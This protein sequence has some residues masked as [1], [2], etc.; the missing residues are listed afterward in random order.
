MFHGSVA[1]SPLGSIQ[2]PPSLP[3]SL[4]LS[5][6]V[7]VVGLPQLTSRW[8]SGSWSCFARWKIFNLLQKLMDDKIFTFSGHRAFKIKRVGFLCH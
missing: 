8:F 1:A 2:R 6:A 5:L 4:S 7:A 3:L